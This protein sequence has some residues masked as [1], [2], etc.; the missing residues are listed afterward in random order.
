MWIDCRK[1]G[2]WNGLEKKLVSF[3][4]K[5]LTGG[6]GC[7]TI[8]SHKSNGT[9]MSHLM[10]VALMYVGL[11]NLIAI[12]NDDLGCA[13]PLMDARRVVFCFLRFST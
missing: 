6:G 2:L 13:L 1:C 9:V 12:V 4:K 5:L 10:G 7:G 8:M 3:S 11:S